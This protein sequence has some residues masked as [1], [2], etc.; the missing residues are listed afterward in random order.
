MS[1]KPYKGFE[2]KWFLKKPTEGSYRSIMKWGDPEK[3]KIPKEGLY[4]IMKKLFNLTDDDFKEGVDLGEE[5][6][7]IKVAPKLDKAAL[8]ALTKIVGAENATTDEFKRAQVCYGKT[9]IDILRL[10]KGILD[11]LPDLV[12]YPATTEQIE[13]IVEFC[14]KSKIYVYVRAGGSSVTRGSECMKS[15]NVILDISKNYNKVVKFN[16]ENQTITVQSG[17]SGPDLERLLNN[18]EQEFGAKMKYTCGHFPQSFEY[19]CV[20]GWVVTRGA[21]QNSTYYGKIE[22]IVLGEEYITPIG[23]IKTDGYPRKAT[24]PDIDQIMMGSEGAY[25]ILTEVTLKVFKLS[26]NHRKFSYMFKSWEDGRNAMREIM[27]GEFGYPSVLRLSDPEETDLMMYMYNIAD[28]PLDTLLKAKGMKADGR[29]LLLGFTDGE[30]G[31]QKNITKNIS[32]IAKKYGALYLTG[33]VTT[34]WEHGRFEDPYM[35]DNLQDFGIII[36]TLEC[37]VNWDNMAYVHE[38]VRKFVKSRPNTICTTHISHSYPQGANLYFIFI[39]KEDN[40]DEFKTFHAGILD[41][42]EKSG[43][44][45]SHHHGIGKLFAPYFAKSAG[46]AKMEV[47]RTLKKHFDPNGIMNAG[48]TLYLDE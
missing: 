37:S 9:M 12:L 11:N 46:E 16:E 41:A 31:L 29:C 7:N 44:A 36:D 20:G 39:I 24:G 25:G 10:R 1:T 30:A 5:I 47:L 35:R 3:N 17:I 32:R 45:V 22:D 18:A 26:E 2:P 48:G 13:K 34:S 6:V 8:D 28:G 40:L 19:S 14:N 33:Y 42:I 43:A 27:Q 23:K 15:P 21:G 38:Y 4:K